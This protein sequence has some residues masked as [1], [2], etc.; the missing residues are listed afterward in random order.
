MGS[1]AHAVQSC[2]S[3]NGAGHVML[4]DAE[5]EEFFAV[6][7]DYESEARKVLTPMMMRRIVE[8]RRAFGRE[9]FISFSGDRIYY[10]VAF[11]EGFLRPYRKAL[12]DEKLFERIFH[13][14]GLGRRLFFS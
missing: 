2:H 9:L 6:Y 4:R 5:F 11:P 3:H 1:L 10:A 14:I 12:N 13:D 8:L 7:A